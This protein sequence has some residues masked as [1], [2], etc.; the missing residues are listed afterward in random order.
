VL[1][2]LSNVDFALSFGEIL[3]IFFAKEM[4]TNCQT[5]ALPV[6]LQEILFVQQF[7]VWSLFSFC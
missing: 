5:S 2:F 7:F 1:D 6:W 4:S 3:Q